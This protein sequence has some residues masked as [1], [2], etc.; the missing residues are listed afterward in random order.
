MQVK[1]KCSQ[2][3]AWSLNKEEMIWILIAIAESQIPDRLIRE[4]VFWIVHFIII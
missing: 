3:M 4:D 1:S 2:T